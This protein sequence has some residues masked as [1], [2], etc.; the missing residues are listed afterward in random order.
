[1]EFQKNNIFL[2]Q[3]WLAKDIKKL[4]KIKKILFQINKN[5][6]IDLQ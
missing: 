4:K 1:L 5:K 6:I 2:N 3:A